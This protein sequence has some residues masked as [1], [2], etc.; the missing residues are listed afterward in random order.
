MCKPPFVRSFATLL[1]PRNDPRN[2]EGFGGEEMKK[3]TMEFLKE[4]SPTGW[5]ALAWLSILPVDPRHPLA[6]QIA[7]FFAML[8]VVH[9]SHLTW[10]AKK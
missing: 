4:M 5:V 9:L 3:A 10:K 8:A 7:G 2:R 6:V 1:N